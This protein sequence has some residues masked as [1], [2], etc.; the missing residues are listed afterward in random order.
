MLFKSLRSKIIVS[1]LLIMI[2]S[3]LFSY[4]IIYYNNYK[5]F[6]NQLLKDEN[7]VLDKLAQNINY[8]IIG[9][10]WLAVA[11]ILDDEI[12]RLL[13]EDTK[14]NNF[15]SFRNSSDISQKLQRYMFSR[16][17][18]FNIAIIRNNG[19]LCGGR[20]LGI[21]DA[22][23]LERLKENWFQNYKVN[24]RKTSDYFTGILQF[25]TANETTNIV[26]YIKTIYDKDDPTKKLGILIIS[27]DFDYIVQV[28]E[29]LDVQFT[30]YFIFNAENEV[31][32]ELPTVNPKKLKEDLSID[33]ASQ[34]NETRASYIL[35]SNTLDNGWKIMEKLSKSKISNEA[36]KDLVP[37][38]LMGF[39][40][41]G[42]VVVVLTIL[43][44]KLTRSIRKLREAMKKV[45]GGN[46]D[47]Y[48]NINTRDEIAE[49]AVVFN[50]MV[51][52]ISELV[53]K[54]TYQEK[55]KKNFEMKALLMQIN[56]HF[57][58]NTLSAVIF[59][60]RKN[61]IDG[62]VTLIGS[63]IHILRKTVDYD[64]V[65]VSLRDEIQYLNEYVNIQK[66]RYED[67]ISVAFEVE[68]K[69][70]GCKI[71]K[72]LL[73]PL[74]ENSLFH[75]ILPK[76]AHGD[77]CV[78]VKKDNDTILFEVWDNGV[79]I[80]PERLEELL[81][82]ETPPSSIDKFSNLGLKNVNERIKLLY[83]NQFGLLLESKVGRGTRISFALPLYMDLT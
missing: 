59:L 9:T 11:V 1:T 29:K 4:A 37:L 75:G 50:N 71:P 28:F 57:I 20:G 33:N 44:F 77:I 69:L 22:Y 2:T 60:A 76:E 45:S 26:N 56:P 68:E 67:M 34:A 70:Y 58:Y 23:L 55:E 46:F 7:I 80:E 25:P 53:D 41:I 10:K 24:E 31:L 13:K 40:S 3:L 52:N 36:R 78:S 74:V 66:I 18:I 16:S 27:M 14:G 49:L 79:G 51:K 47:V 5:T 38:I 62:I 72:M 32:Y 54:V 81:L 17:S 48:I 12:Q 6:Q 64:V 82:V 65:F 19:E 63:L 8:S 30:S 15:K 39:C 73:Q 42:L 43:M 21:N 35:F 61:N 83:G